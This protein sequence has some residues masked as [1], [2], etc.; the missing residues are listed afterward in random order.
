MARLPD[1]DFLSSVEVSPPAPPFGTGGPHG[2]P[3]AAR[4][5]RA[6]VLVALAGG[7]KEP[8]EELQLR[9]LGRLHRASDDFGA[10][11][12]LRV[13]EAA[14]SLIPHPEELAAEQRRAKR[15]RRR[16]WRRRATR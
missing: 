1:H 13:V 15:P 6:E 9:Y 16:W 4:R 3:A 8:V 14:L 10:T 2:D 12:G 5:R 7:R 11:E